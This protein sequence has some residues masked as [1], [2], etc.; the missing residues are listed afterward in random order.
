MGSLNWWR[1]GLGVADDGSDGVGCAGGDGGATGDLMHVVGAG[2]SA[3]AGRRSGSTTLAQLLH[4][5]LV[6]T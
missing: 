6:L 3:S 4:S 2:S 5:G 1:W